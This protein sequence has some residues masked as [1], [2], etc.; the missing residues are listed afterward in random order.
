[1]NITLRVSIVFLLIFLSCGDS[2]STEEEIFDPQG[3]VSWKIGNE[4]FSKSGSWTYCDIEDFSGN[5]AVY[6]TNRVEG[7]GIIIIIDDDPN[8]VAAGKSYA[9]DDMTIGQIIFDD[10]NSNRWSSK[11]GEGTGMI[12]V[13]QF[14]L[15]SR[16]AMEG[17]FSGILYNQDDN[18]SR[19]IEEG[20]FSVRCL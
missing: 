16:S 15:E 9:F 1:M 8:A 6:G 11:E 3:I 10:G 13:T 17:T 20:F 5:I 18:S 14:S 7:E 12:K 19:S 2:E 4:S